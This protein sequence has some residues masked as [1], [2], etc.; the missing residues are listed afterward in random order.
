[1]QHVKMP[2][3]PTLM[4]SVGGEE[5]ARIGLRVSF[6]QQFVS[7]CKKVPLLSF[8]HFLLKFLTKIYTLEEFLR[9]V[10]EELDP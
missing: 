2:Y 4:G 6:F 7:I 1:M 10:G 8:I 3:Q 5:P 9:S